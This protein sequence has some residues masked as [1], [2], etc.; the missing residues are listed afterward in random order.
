[1]K[2][3]GGSASHRGQTGKELNRRKQSVALIQTKRIYQIASENDRLFVLT[4]QNFSV[5]AGAFT[6]S[7]TDSAGIDLV[8]AFMGKF[9]QAGRTSAGK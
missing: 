3:T 4:C 7:L 6:D 2:Q 5:L 1:M 9:A 8:L